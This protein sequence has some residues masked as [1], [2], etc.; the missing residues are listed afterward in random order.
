[1][2]EVDDLLAGLKGIKA[3]AEAVGAVEAKRKKDQKSNISA[4]DGL[5]SSR[6]SGFRLRKSDEDSESNP[7]VLSFD[8]HQTKKGKDD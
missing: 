6:H 1:M 3:F 8:R 2:S 7:Q 4:L 5:K